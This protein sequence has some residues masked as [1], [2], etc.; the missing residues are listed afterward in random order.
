M[1]RRTKHIFDKQKIDEQHLHCSPQSI[2]KR[3]QTEKQGQ[4]K[5][6]QEQL[7]ELGDYLRAVKR[8]EHHYPLYRSRRIR[9]VA[10]A[11]Q[12]HMLNHHLHVVL[13]V[14]TKFFAGGN[15]KGTP[16]QRYRYTC[17][18]HLVTKN[19]TKRGTTWRTSRTSSSSHSG[20]GA[21]TAATGTRH[22]SSVGPPWTRMTTRG[23]T[24]GGTT[25]PPPILLDVLAKTQT[26][27]HSTY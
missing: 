26:P 7:K 24:C 17:N 20:G 2:A 15:I 18:V 23:N 11:L 5:L 19:C 16:V 8:W 21:V 22:H 6:C 12:E 10:K 9:L 14:E 3:T 27:H 4:N 1:P 13:Y 25:L